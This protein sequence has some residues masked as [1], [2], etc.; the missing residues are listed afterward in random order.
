MES[1]EVHFEPLVQLPT[2]EVVTH[3]EE[4]EELLQL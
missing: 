4:E 1:P 2:V 3:E